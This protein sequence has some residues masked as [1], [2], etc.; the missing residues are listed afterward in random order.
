MLSHAKFIFVFSH[1]AQKIRTQKSA[2]EMWLCNATGRICRECDK[3]L[4][5]LR[6]LKWEK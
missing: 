4:G 1:V 6:S 5:E 2:G 3:Q